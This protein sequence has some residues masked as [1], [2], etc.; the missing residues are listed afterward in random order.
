MSIEPNPV[1]PR[2][3]R[4]TFALLSPGLWVTAE[5]EW[6]LRPG[7]SYWAVIGVRKPASGAPPRPRPLALRTPHKSPNCRQDLVA[8]SASGTTVLC[9]CYAQQ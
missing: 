9:S 4:S 7:L 1:I 3:L 5:N 6:V 2:A 8:I